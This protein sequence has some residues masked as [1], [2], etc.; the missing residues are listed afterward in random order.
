MSEHEVDNRPLLSICIP[1][2]NRANYLRNC[3]ESLE[4]AGEG[5]WENIEVL[6]SDNASNDDTKDVVAEFQRRFPLR[7]FRNQTNI[8]GEPNFFAAASRATA[9]HVWVFGDDDEFGDQAIATILPY[10]RQDYD[11]I[12]ANF[13]S[14]SREMDVQLSP[15]YLPWTANR[16][17]DDP[18]QVLATFGMHM[19]FISSLIVRKSIYFSVPPD[20]YARFTPFGIPH[21]YSIYCGILK[22]HRIAYI[23]AALFKQRSDNCLGFK[24]PDAMTNLIHVFVHGPALMYYALFE[25]G[26]GRT[27]IR[28]V[29]NVHLRTYYPVRYVV[30]AIDQLDKLSTLRMMFRYY[31]TSS[32][33]WFRWVPILLSPR[34]VTRTLH[35]ALRW[36][37]SGKNS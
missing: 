3:L 34:F 25:K 28:K 7:Y 37:R 4:R 13:S 33:F 32:T 6:V 35:K 15:S 5:W 12:I 27:T 16:T 10:I 1:T 11:L 9:Q 2:F 36:L 19:S 22:E 31:R 18:N 14:W 23:S 21:P 24:G 8:G 20:D 17:Y 30:G 29:K 26:Y